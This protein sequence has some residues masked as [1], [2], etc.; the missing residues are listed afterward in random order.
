MH[1]YDFSSLSGLA[2]C[3]LSGGICLDFSC[4]PPL[5]FSLTLVQ[6]ISQ[7]FKINNDGDSSLCA[8]IDI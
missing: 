5:F 8:K 3:F 4:G 6:Y 2:E 7:C 1:L